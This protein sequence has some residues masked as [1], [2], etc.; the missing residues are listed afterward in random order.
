MENANNISTYAT[1]LAIILSALF[2]YWGI[3]IG[4]AELT[5]F[6]TGLITI[7]IAIWSS[8]NPNDIGWLGNSKPQP[9]TTETVLNDEY[10]TNNGDTDAE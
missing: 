6:A 10:E 2:N 1:W 4:Q 5:L 8:R 9:Q 7:I 3:E